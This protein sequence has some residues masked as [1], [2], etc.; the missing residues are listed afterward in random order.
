ME[1][2]IKKLINA[3]TTDPI[4]IPY[5]II[6]NIILKKDEKDEMIIF[7]KEIEKILDKYKKKIKDSMK[8]LYLIEEE[9]KINEKNAKN[10]NILTSKNIKELS[11]KI[12]EDIK[13]HGRMADE[14]KKMIIDFNLNQKYIVRKYCE[15]YIEKFMKSDRFINLKYKY[16][17]FSQTLLYKYPLKNINVNNIIVQVKN[18]SILLEMYKLSSLDEPLLFEKMVKSLLINCK[19]KESKDYIMKLVSKSPPKPKSKSPPKPDPKKEVYIRR[20]RK[21]WIKGKKHHKDAL[22]IFIKNPTQ[23]RVQTP[24]EDGGYFIA[25]FSKVAGDVYKYVDESQKIIEITYITPDQVGFINRMMDD[26]DFYKPNSPPKTKPN[27]PLKTESNSPPKTKPNSP[28]KTKPNSPPKPNP[29]KEEVYISRNGRTW[30]KGKKHHKDALDIFIKNPT[31]S[32]VQTPHKDGG[33]FVGYFAKVKDD[34]YTYIDE[35]GKSINIM[36]STPSKVA[37]INRMNDW[38]EEDDTYYKKQYEDWGWESNLPKETKDKTSIIKLSDKEIKLF[39]KHNLEIKV[40]IDQLKNNYKKLKLKLH[41]DKKEGNAE[42][43]I[44]MKELYDRRFQK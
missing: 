4:D 39:Q 42:E 27:S 35:S 9:I 23:S 13:E 37:F 2:I 29:E 20:D 32:R 11:K 10:V 38:A 40:N 7:D 21:K 34:F 33:Y 5:M 8:K 6:I 41:P 43:F 14:I 31:K 24:H 30:V 22:D 17:L 36:Y 44:Y 3:L 26:Q 18:L 25:N 19:S 15:D 16:R 12:E 28:P 1:L